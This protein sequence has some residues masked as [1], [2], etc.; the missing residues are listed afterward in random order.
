M[1]AVKPIDEVRSTL[2]RMGE[3]FKRALPPHIHPEKFV[4]VAMTAIQKNPGLLDLDRHSLYGAC[5]DAAQDGLLP[6]GKQ[7]ALV[8]FKGRVAYM[9]MVYG[10]LVKVRN[11]GELATIVSEIIYQADKFSYRVDNDGPHLEHVPNLFAEDR[12]AIMGAYALAKTKDGEVY[13]DAMTHAQIEKTRAVSRSKDGP[14][15]DWWEEM[16][17][18]TVLR[19]LS[20]RLPMSTDDEQLWGKEDRL[21]RDVTPETPAIAAIARPVPAALPPE[22]TKTRLARIVGAGKKEDPAMAPEPVPSL[23]EFEGPPEDN[24]PGPVPEL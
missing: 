19:R 13:V 6:D 3:Q 1:T 10:I 5:M 23:E 2:E 9:P 11:S 15:K 22:K 12:G 8:P 14:W 7:A 18:K 4:R 17:K 20:K 24:A 16:A 21:H